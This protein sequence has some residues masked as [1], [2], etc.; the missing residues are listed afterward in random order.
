M[1]I[2]KY[3]YLFGF[4]LLFICISGNFAEYINLP[5]STEYYLLPIKLGAKEAINITIVGGGSQIITTSTTLPIT[6]LTIEYLGNMK[7]QIINPS[8]N[9]MNG[10]IPVP[11]GSIDPYPQ[12]SEP[13]GLY[14]NVNDLLSR[15][16]IH[17]LA[18]RFP[19]IIPLLGVFF[20]LMVVIRN[21][22]EIFQG[23]A[24]MIGFYAI[25]NII[26]DGI[27]VECLSNAPYLTFGILLLNIIL[28]ANKFL[29]KNQ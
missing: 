14:Y 23:L 15:N 7:Y 11:V 16:I 13:V 5:Y 21:R 18:Q 20:E 29:N 26:F 22:D 12:I 1:S 10:Y 19:Y 24:V 8:N 4:I 6:N 27:V 3:I 9:I 17:S 28:L 2:K 25:M